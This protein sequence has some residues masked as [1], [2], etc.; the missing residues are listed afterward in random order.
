[1][2]MKR[3]ML[4]LVTSLV[5]LAILIAIAFFMKKES[6]TFDSRHPDQDN[7]LSETAPSEAETAGQ[8]Q[9]E[10]G[11][12]ESG[13]GNGA[14][15]AMSGNEQN[16]DQNTSG[17]AGRNSGQEPAEEMTETE[18]PEEKRTLP[19][20]QIIF[21]GDSR[22]IGL[23]NALKKL[24]PDDDCVCVGKV[25]EGCKWFLEEGEA[26]MAD[27]IKQYPQAPV[28]LNFGVND[29]DQIE[30]YLE[31]YKE[32]EEAYPDTKFWY[33]S[34]NPI[35]TD[36]MIEYGAS[37]DALELVTDTNIRKLNMALQQAHPDRYL[38][39]YTVLKV[40]GFTTVDGLHYSRQ[41]YL[42]IHRFIVS[43]LFE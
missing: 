24:L 29:P 21:V 27:A 33:M 3:F 30:Q 1:M 22:T 25:G 8:A 41:T 20:H 23:Q 9:N 38:D 40:G 19:K 5:A 4:M 28:V 13:Q 14:G 11:S 2:K 31:A 7:P 35:Q 42:K 16:A 17:L 32:M 18:M 10:E 43:Q 12:S 15:N 37:Q 39:S 6:D 36:K 34:V 26:Q